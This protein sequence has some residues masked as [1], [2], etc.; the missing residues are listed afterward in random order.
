[1]TFAI[2][3]RVGADRL[4]AG[5]P[6]AD[7]AARPR[8][9]RARPRCPSRSAAVVA[10]QPHERVDEAGAAA[11]RDRHAALLHRDRDHLRHE[12]GR[13]R[14]RAEARCAAPTARAGRARA[15]RRTSSSS[16]SRL[17]TSRLPANS[18]AP[19]RPSR[20]N[21]LQRE[22]RALPSTRARCR[23]RRRRGRRSGRTPRAR[24][25][26]RRRRP[27]RGG[28]ARPRSPRRCAAGTR[29]R[30]RG[31]AV[32]VGSSVFRYS[33]PRAASSSPSCACAAPPT[34]SGCQALKT[35]CTVARLG[36]LGGADR[37]RRASRCAPARRRCQPA[38]ASS[39]RRRAS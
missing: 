32:A 27:A 18:T 30:R 8:R 5:E 33:S 34:Q 38:R 15:R 19:A 36:D 28:R 13:R 4:A 26:R 6:H 39:A 7:G 37:R 21:A 35:S 31:R 10:D 22:R 17:E 23:A 12:A 3:A 16:Q 29:P 1:M 11:A 9:A 14:V 25:A 20:R 24:R 2:T